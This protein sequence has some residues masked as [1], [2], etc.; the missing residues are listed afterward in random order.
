MAVPR[1]IA[2]LSAALAVSTLL[3]LIAF[4]ALSDAAITCSKTWN[5]NTG[6]WSTPSEWTPAGAPAST[7][8]V[9]VPSGTVTRDGA[10][11]TVAALSVSG[12]GTLV[13]DGVTVNS[14][15]VG[16]AS[17]D[18]PVETAGSG[19]VVLTSIAGSASS[20]LNGGALTNAGTIQ[21]VVGS[22]GTRSISFS[23]GADSGTLDLDYT[24][25]ITFASGWSNTGTID[26]AANQQINSNG[27]FTMDG[28]SFMGT[29]TYAFLN[30][31]VVHNNG[32]TGLNAAVA[33]VGG[34]L[35][36]SGTGSASYI[37]AASDLFG[38]TT[39]LGSVA[40][41]KTVRILGGG[42][43]GQATA[44]TTTNLTNNGTIVLESLAGVGSQDATLAIGTG[45]TLT[46]AGTI[47]A[48]ATSG[49]ART[50]GGAGALSNGAAG[51]INVDT[52]TTFSGP[53]TNAGAFTVAASTTATI[54]TN[55][56]TQTN[57]TTSV[58]GTLD[59]TGP[60][61]VALGGGVLQGTGTVAGNVNNSAGDVRPGTSPG[62][63][64]IGG[65]YTQG[66]AGKLTVEITPPGTVSDYDRLIV[67]GNATLGGTLLV[68][69]ETHTPGNGDTFDILT[70]SGTA[71]GTF[72]TE[73]GLAS[74]GGG[75][76]YIV[77]YTVGPPGRVRLATIDQFALTVNKTGSSGSGSVTSTPSGINCD[78]SNTDCAENYDTGTSVTLSASPAAGS[79]FGGWS[80]AGCSGTGTC[81]VTMSQARTATANFIKVWDL[82]VTKTSSG[83]GT[84]TSSP[85]GVSCGIDCAETYDTDT[86]VT[87][88]AVASAGSRFTGWSGG[89]P[90]CSGTGTC[91][92]GMTQAQAVTAN[93]VLEWVLTVNKTGSGSGTVTSSPAGISCGVDCTETYDNST[94]ATLT[95]AP[96]AGS[97]FTGWSGEGCSGTGTCTVA[98][99][100]ARS[101]TA[102]F[103]Q[104]DADGDG[105]PQ[106]QDCDDGN[107]AIHP[108]ATDVPG[109]AVDEDCS[110]SDAQQPAPPD[111][112]GDGLPDSTDP[113]PNDPSIPT[114]FGADNGNNTLTGTAA[115]ETICGL[116]G[117]DVV[118]ALGGN[119]IL[120]GDLCNVKAK[121][122]AAQ[123][124]TG[125]NDT[126]NGGTGND[127]VYGAAGNDKLSG[128]DGNDKLFGGDGN[129]TLSGGK[130]NDSLDGGNGNDK[131]TGG[132]GVNAYNGGAGN[133]S[134]N[135]RN[136]KKETVNCGTGKSDKATV[137][138]ADKVKGCEQVKRAK[139]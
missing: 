11:V 61:I 5:G 19:K 129:D 112:D 56:F 127:T 106:L 119:D 89:T 45:T 105:T 54:A 50:I 25:N 26:T 103:A 2:V 23:T 97:S 15:A 114:A 128:D 88:T 33:V 111:S 43:F 94:S 118:S 101:V 135:A 102:T 83:S 35:D 8:A 96:A 22:G 72:A 28:G 36:A 64:T 4:A 30:A 110:G 48:S 126:L 131:L 76:A 122:A 39:L 17:N 13:I 37:V 81:Q 73:T 130:G 82:T 87:L 55:N 133:D 34:S 108:G 75:R 70:A 77:Q 42:G 123:A 44:V 99:T 139:N 63:L 134:I 93:F 53:V 12:N 9:C 27:D 86:S 18:G 92:V 85:G 57:G 59:P 14:D 113:A 38:A 95:A 65:D 49:G 120:F 66:S 67:T 46:N 20:A 41:N 24:A 69:S 51:T 52:A 136:G 16:G 3:M 1:R 116:L 71:T 62:Q 124:G 125:G 74:A 32:T 104:I 98:M 29:G 60:S 91:V 40:T 6:N 138:K 79:R 68:Q 31:D 47:T 121:L 100:Q 107:A 115:G 109:N 10:P 80:G 78:T 58:I 21:T 137:D 84:V 90:A 117:D 132:A 7:D